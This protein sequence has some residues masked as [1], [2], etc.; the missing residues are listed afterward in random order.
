M[1]GKIIIFSAPS[2]AGKT[3]IAKEILK[4]IPELIFSVS[5]CSRP[6]RNGERDGVD[7][8]F[9]SVEDFKKKIDNNEFL[10]WQE[11][12]PGSYYGTLKKEV[13][14]IWQEGKN[15]MF[16]VDTFGGINIKN[17]YKEKAL[18][19]FI[20]TLT[21]EILNERLTS[22]GTESQDS[23]KKRMDK[24]NIELSHSNEFDK[25]IINDNLNKAIEEA[26][27]TITEF[28]NN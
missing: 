23:L 14:R 13:E 28:L 4:R 21:P 1:S 2:G 12:Y 24:A 7:Y 27:T 8:Y 18:S 15:V 17:I 11:V 20:K 25:I 16:D 19:I 3:T 5:A 6:M 10:E 22:R 9:L 26:Y